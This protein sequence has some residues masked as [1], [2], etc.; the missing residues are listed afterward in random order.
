MAEEMAEH[1]VDLEQVVAG[2]RERVERD[3]AAGA[4]ADELSR[5]ELERPHAD[6]PR[7]RFRPELGFSSKP[8]IGRPITVTKRLLLRLQLYVFDDLARQADDAIQAVERRLEVEIATR[9]RLEGQVSELEAR[10]RRLE[11]PQRRER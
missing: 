7:V 1:P 10:I 9:E 4:Y 5:F 8:V 6:G 11:E 3:R 2:L